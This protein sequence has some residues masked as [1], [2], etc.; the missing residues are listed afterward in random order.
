MPAG[1]LKCCCKACD[2]EKSWPGDNGRLSCVW[3]INSPIP[4]TPSQK[5]QYIH[6]SSSAWEYAAY[7]YLVDSNV[8]Y[9]YSQDP[10]NAGPGKL[11]F[12]VKDFLIKKRIRFQHPD[13]PAW[14]HNIACVPKYEDFQDR[15]QPYLGETAGVLSAWDSRF[16]YRYS[17]D[18]NDP[19]HRYAIKGDKLRCHG[20]TGR[21]S[22]YGDV[23]KNETNYHW[24]W[25][26]SNVGVGIGD[27][28]TIGPGTTVEKDFIDT[29]TSFLFTNEQQQEKHFHNSYDNT[30]TDKCNW[31]NRWGFCGWSLF[32]VLQDDSAQFGSTMVNVD[33]SFGSTW[34][35][36]QAMSG[37]G[38]GYSPFA[39]VPPVG[40]TPIP[41]N[42]VGFGSTPAIVECR[43]T[44][45]Y[46][47]WMGDSI[48]CNFIYVEWVK[49][50]N[51][52]WYRNVTVQP[53]S[54]YVGVNQPN[55]CYDNVTFPMRLVM[56]K[57]RDNPFST[58]YNVSY[59]NCRYSL[60][61]NPT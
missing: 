24:I 53:E 3:N 45:D 50:D 48:A 1:F 47:T 18:A 21:P 9:W 58:S 10:G 26:P 2:C 14:L 28:G 44:L 60:Q 51:G 23:P 41:P 55:L 30:P 56:W 40:Q 38:T 43:W 54:P 22:P 8:P 25:R 35:Q 31:R 29:Y 61:W 6:R 27:P 4:G 57:W 59:H 42:A 15:V 5:Y 49:L 52:R 32:G 13:L 39:F 37:T 34:Q 7:Q 46:T 33:G 20:F 17:L 11:K 19:L 36:T 12:Y 16:L